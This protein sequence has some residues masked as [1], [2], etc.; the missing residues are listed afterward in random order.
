MPFVSSF[1]NSTIKLD[2]SLVKNRITENQLASVRPQ[3]D[4]AAETLH[5]KTGEG[6]GFLGWLDPGGIISP[7]ELA[8]LKETASRLRDSTD[9]LV[10]VGIGGSYLGERACYDA[11]RVPGSDYILRY[12][13]TNIST[14]YHIDLM[15]SLKGKRFAINVISKSGTTTEPAIAFKLLL[16]ELVASVGNGKAGDLV[17]ATTDARKGALRELTDAEG[18]TSFVVPDNVGGR[19]SVLTPVGL[20]PLAYAGIDVDALL[21]GASDCAVACRG[22]Q[23]DT[24]PCRLYAAIRHLLYKDRI[25]IELLAS[26]EPRLE[27]FIE[28]WK[29]LAGE[30]EGKNHSGLFPAGVI[31]TRD[32]HSL[33]QYIQDGARILFETFLTVGSG[34]PSLLVPGDTSNSDDELAYLTGKELTHINKLAQDATMQAHAEGGCPNM[35]IT[36]PKMDPYHLGVLIYF[37]EYATALSGYLSGVNPFDQ[38]GVEVYKK[39]MYELLGKPGAG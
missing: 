28:W 3:T 13:G 22:K 38:P 12:A 30:S 5:S 36:V 2:A 37:F 35:N 27:Q 23:L 29:Q 32:L 24:N 26:F 19:F 14:H 21:A 15:D 4:A 34:E 31:F 9:I 16:D 6:S 18:W 11:L 17:I 39:K 10:V 25:S 8:R 20:F 7:S 33:G 1:P